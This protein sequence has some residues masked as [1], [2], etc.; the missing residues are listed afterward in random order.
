MTTLPSTL[1]A[2]QD[3]PHSLSLPDGETM[4]AEFAAIARFQALV[5][6]TMIEGHDFGVIPGTGNKPTLL[7]P[8]AEKLTKLLGLRESYEF[9]DRIDDYDRPLF[10]Y[11]IKCTLIHIASGAAVTEGLGECNSMESKYRYRWVFPND[12]PAGFDKAHAVTRRARNG[13]TMYR[14]DSDDVHSQVNTILKMAM[15][16]AL[17]SAALSAGRLSDLFTQD[18]ED[19]AANG[20]LGEDSAPASTTTEA[21]GGSGSATHCPIHEGQAWRTNK[22]GGEYHMIGSGK[23]AVFCNPHQAYAGLLGVAL[24]AAGFAF[25]PD[26][27]GLQEKADK[28]SFGAYVKGHY[29]GRT[30]SKLNAEECLATVEAYQSLAKPTEEA[31]DEAEQGS[32]PEAEAED[33]P[34]KQ[35]DLFGNEKEPPAG[36]TEADPDLPF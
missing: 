34:A 9:L 25:D 22:N 36:A 15:K 14:I 18:V 5:R 7:K 16:R 6:E 19:L 31:K 35:T 21:T 2:V 24:K 12:V 13:G 3:A 27:G 11:L 8:G 23:D 26:K 4:Q 28:E 30:W 10:R 1:P 29:D 20:V 17:V 32:E 33:T